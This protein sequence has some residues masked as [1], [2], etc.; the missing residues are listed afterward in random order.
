MESVLRQA[1]FD[2]DREALLLP[3]LMSDE[4]DWWLE[5]RLHL[6]SHRPVVGGLIVCV[7]RRVIL[8][9]VRWLYNFSLENFRRQRHVNRLLF[10][11]IEELAIENAKLR[12]DVAELRG[13]APERRAGESGDGG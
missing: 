2:R 8:P 10:A 12:R 3:E 13:T 5:T 9:L 6:A 4:D 11:C 1:V 7:K